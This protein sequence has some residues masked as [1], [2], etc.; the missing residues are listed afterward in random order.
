MVLLVVS[1]LS[2]FFFPRPKN[3]RLADVESTSSAAGFDAITLS[4]RCSD[5][6][7]GVVEFRGDTDSGLR[8]C[9]GGIERVVR[10]PLQCSLNSYAVRAAT[11]AST[12]GLR[13][14]SMM[15]IENGE[16]LPLLSIQ[17]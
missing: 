17:N 4:C 6:I 8:V 9:E 13:Y 11:L 16:V 12:L 14:G 5:E 3:F 10:R 1:G 2:S 15:F 7:S